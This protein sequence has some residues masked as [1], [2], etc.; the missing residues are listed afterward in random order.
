M[1]SFV[2][3]FEQVKHGRIEIKRGEMQPVMPAGPVPHASKGFRGNPSRRVA[4]PT[5]VEGRRSPGKKDAA[6]MKASPKTG[7]AV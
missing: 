3:L 6:A 7:A 5:N 4:Q 1:G 2:I